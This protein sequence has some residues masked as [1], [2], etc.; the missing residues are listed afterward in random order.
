MRDRLTGVAYAGGWALVR[1]LPEPVA[2]R[3]VLAG[4]EGPLAHTLG[5]GLVIAVTETVT[6]QDID[7]LEFALKEVLK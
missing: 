3:L 4:I 2:Q 6:A 5:F 1:A 7:A